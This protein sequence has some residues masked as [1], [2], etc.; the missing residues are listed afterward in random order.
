[1]SK[2]IC[3]IKSYKFVEFISSWLKKQGCLTTSIHVCRAWPMCP[4][5]TNLHSCFLSFDQLCQGSR[6]LWLPTGG[7]LLVGAVMCNAPFVDWWWLLTGSSVMSWH[8]SDVTCPFPEYISSSSFML[9]MESESACFSTDFTVLLSQPSVGCIPLESSLEETF[10]FGSVMSMLPAA[11][12]LEIVST[13]PSSNVLQAACFS[14]AT[15][16]PPATGFF[17][18]CLGPAYG[19]SLINKDF[20]GDG[21][22]V[23]KF[24]FLALFF[25]P[26]ER[27]LDWVIVSETQ[28]WKH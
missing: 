10:T 19:I 15:W 4:F 26:F 12:R 27:L 16:P 22:L 8:S 1:M 20:V 3:V 17:W 13:D 6:L 2:D 5:I 24:D 18:Y 9:A 7:V 21:C 14:Q 11:C 23:F 25:F 28:I